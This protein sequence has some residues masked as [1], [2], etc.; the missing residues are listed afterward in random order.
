MNTSH[1][2]V[3]SLIELLVKKA[4][5]DLSKNYS[6]IELQK[7]KDSIT[8]LMKERNSSTNKKELAGFIENLKV[9]QANWENNAEMV[10]RSLLKAYEEGKDYNSVK[11][12]I[13]LLG[14]LALKGTDNIS[15]GSVYDRV[16]SLDN[17]YKTL[18]EK[19]DSTDYSNIEEKEMDARYKTYLENKLSNIDTELETL[20]KELDSLR[21]VEIKDV[22]IVSKIKE[23][24]DKLS[25]DKEKIDKA[26]SSS[27]SSNIAFDTWERLEKAKNST[28]E[29]LDKAKDLLEK[30]ENTLQDVKKNQGIIKDRKTSLETEKTRCNTKLNSIN[31]KIEEN[32]YEN[33][34]ERMI[35]VNNSEMMKLELEQLN[36]KKD[37]IYVDVGKVKEELIREWKKE[38]TPVT[39]PPKIKEEIV[40]LEET[41]IVTEEKKEVKEAEQKNDA[42]NEVEELLREIDEIKKISVVKEELKNDVEIK[43][44]AVLNKEDLKE[45]GIAHEDNKITEEIDQVLS[46]ITTESKVSLPKEEVKEE[47]KNKIELD[48]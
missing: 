11:M 45:K 32:T 19:I 38:R 46:E 44:E 9:R 36:N 17:D 3:V 26:V 5:F 15:V 1:E 14:N 23:Y 27:I 8:S 31:T 4:G 16:K 18:L 47:K 30:T 35:D 20:E 24:I 10:G 13:E 40:Q 42:V 12:R 43:K 29:K 34:T 37:V 21:E 7:T 2:A 25:S 6:E 22:G 33:T 41:P 39:K 48:W 28:N